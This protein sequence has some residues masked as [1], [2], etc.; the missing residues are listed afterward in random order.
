MGIIYYFHACLSIFF[1]ARLH[2]CQRFAKFENSRLI[3]AMLD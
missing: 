2:L 3:M 1:F